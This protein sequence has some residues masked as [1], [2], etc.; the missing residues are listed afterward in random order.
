VIVRQEVSALVSIVGWT[1]YGR[2]LLDHHP[3]F[4]FY[5]SGDGDGDGELARKGPI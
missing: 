2:D 3:L 1:L 4:S 5:I